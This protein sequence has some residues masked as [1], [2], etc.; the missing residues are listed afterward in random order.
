MSLPNPI[1][2]ISKIRKFLTDKVGVNPFIVAVDFYDV[3]DASSL[4]VD[5]LVE[6]PP[7]KF[8]S[9]ETKMSPYPAIPENFSGAIIDYK[10]VI[11][12]SIGRDKQFV[13][14]N[15]VI[16]GIV[17]A[18]DNTAR[19]GT[20]A[21]IFHGS[22]PRLFKIWLA[23]LR[24]LTREQDL[25]DSQKFIF[26]NA[27]NEWA[28]GAH[29]EPDLLHGWEY[30]DSIK[31]T[32]TYLSNEHHFELARISKELNF[33]DSLLPKNFVFSSAFYQEFPYILTKLS[34]IIR[35]CSPKLHMILVRMYMSI[36]GH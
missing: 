20:S 1:G 30:L 26:V 22:S 21:V 4:G 12:Q 16:R 5:A 14:E 36:K 25:P 10:K 9:Q 2:N 28:E 35:A 31:G 7:H 13:S 18:W 11:L 33:T 34:K 3:N 23:A 29:L 32:E 24:Q 17:P 27:W 8:W 6:F 15:K 19:K